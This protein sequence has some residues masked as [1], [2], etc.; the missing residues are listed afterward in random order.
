VVLADPQGRPFASESGYGGG[1]VQGGGPAVYLKQMNQ[2]RKVKADRDTALEKVRAAAGPGR[3]Q[4]A[5]EALSFLGGHKLLPY[6][7]SVWAEWLAAAR[8]DDPGNDRGEAEQLFEAYWKQRV[9]GAGPHEAGEVMEFLRKFE[10][11]REGL[12]F[13]DPV[14]ATRMFLEAAVFAEHLDD[15]GQAAELARE[16]RPYARAANDAAAGAQ[17][18]RLSQMGAGSGTGFVIWVADRDAYLLTNNHVIRGGGSVTVR[19]PGAPNPVHARVLAKDSRRDIALIKLTV[20]PGAPALKP[21]S[22][23][24][25]LAG[26]G[27][28]VAALG[29]PLGERFGAGLKLT[30]GVVSALPEAGNHEMLMLDAKVNPGNSGGPLCD[31]TGAVV[32]M[33]SQKTIKST[34]VIDNYGMAVPV[35]DLRDFLKRHLPAYSPPAPPGEQFPWAVVDRKVSGSVLMIVTE[36]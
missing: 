31:A 30:T 9:G 6:Y 4:A 18:E 21:L 15:H 23:G 25:R 14:R 3:A 32:G 8:R 12:K 7:D 2:S 10:E 36:P 27:E 20:P 22:L 11:F 17:F 28:S 29:Y 13:K 35:K 1:G 33:V 24:D 16:G 34:E 5:E 26:R 19:M